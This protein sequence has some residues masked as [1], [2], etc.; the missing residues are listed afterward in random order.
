MC[1]WR[2]SSVVRSGGGWVLCLSPTSASPRSS[3]HNKYTPA[4]APA[5]PLLLLGHCHSLSALASGVDEMAETLVL[6]HWSAQNMRPPP[7]TSHHCTA[8]ASKT[9][10]NT[11]CQAKHGSILEAGSG[12]LSASCARGKAT[13]KAR[14]LTCCQPEGELFASL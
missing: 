9:S 11:C 13:G 14:I 6:V 7:P 12:R 1:G 2:A 8:T 3:C 5:L 10:I 4:P